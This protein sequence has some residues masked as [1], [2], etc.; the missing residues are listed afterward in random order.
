MMK[1]AI[2]MNQHL[3]DLPSLP[4]APTGFMGLMR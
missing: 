3:V 2:P 4:E 1:E